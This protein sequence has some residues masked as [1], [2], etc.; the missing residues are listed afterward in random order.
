[1][2]EIRFRITSTFQQIVAR[3]MFVG[4]G[5]YSPKDLTSHIPGVKPRD[6]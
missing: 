5:A 1:V 4:S 3:V 6:G 2:E